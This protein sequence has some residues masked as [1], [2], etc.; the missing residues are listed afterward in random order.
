MR[1]QAAAE[2]PISQQPRNFTSRQP[3]ASNPAASHQPPANGP[4]HNVRHN[5]PESTAKSGRC[6][7]VQPPSSSPH[8]AESVT[9]DS[10]DPRRCRLLPGRRAGGGGGGG[11]HGPAR[12]RLSG[13]LG[14]SLGR[15]SLPCSIPAAA[16][17]AAAAAG[18]HNQFARP[19]GTGRPAG[20]RSAAAAGASRGCLVTGPAR[21]KLG[22]ARRKLRSWLRPLAHELD[23]CA[24]SSGHQRSG[25]DCTVFPWR[26]GR[27][28][29]STYIL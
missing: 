2:P 1:R 7:A 22:P 11:G 5:P 25:R 27:L 28:C 14:R 3:Q 12:R 17:A 10:P 21:R 6:R 19:P 9:P 16:A 29:A 18:R 8:S 4:S 20:R 23:S 13:R 15:R 26:R 24:A